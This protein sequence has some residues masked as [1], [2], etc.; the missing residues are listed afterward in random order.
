LEARFSRNAVIVQALADLGFVERL[1]YGL[2]RVVTVMR[3]NNLPPPLFEEAAGAFRVTLFSPAI[4]Q[5]AASLPDL[6][7][8]RSLNLN[9]RQQMALGYIAQNRR[10]TNSDYQALCPDVHPETLRRDLADLVSRGVLIKVGD[11]KATYYILK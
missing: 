6:S 3:Q 8:Y 9:P 7:V 2:D 1:G 4:S 5:P 11:K 10:I